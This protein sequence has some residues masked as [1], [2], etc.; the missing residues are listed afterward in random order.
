[1]PVLQVGEPEEIRCFDERQ[2]I[3]GPHLQIARQLVHVA[4]AADGE[5]V[6]HE[7]G[8]IIDTDIGQCL[9]SSRATADSLGLGRRSARRPARRPVRRRRAPDWS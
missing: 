5:Q 8:E 6:L 4:A 3:V 1:M 9:I 7:S 2:E